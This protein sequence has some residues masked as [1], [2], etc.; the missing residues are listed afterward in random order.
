MFWNSGETVIW[1]QKKILRKFLIHFLSSEVVQT[2]DYFSNA[3]QN[4]WGVSAGITLGIVR[5]T[6]SRESAIVQV[7]EHALLKCSSCSSCS[8]CSTRVSFT[9]TLQTWHPVAPILMGHQQCVMTVRCHRSCYIHL[10]RYPPYLRS[11]PV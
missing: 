7:N 3:R 6:R 1:F 10:P 5:G 8:S 11:P 2:R 9:V 4:L